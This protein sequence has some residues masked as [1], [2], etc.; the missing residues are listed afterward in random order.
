MSTKKTS[1]KKTA[2][3]TPQKKHPK[4]K[5]PSSQEY[6]AVAKGHLDRVQSAWYEPTDWANLTM[7]GLYCLEAGI[8]A[9][10]TSLSWDVK[11]THWDKAELAERLHKEQGLSDVSALLPVLN[12]GRKAMAYGDIDFDESEYDAQDIATE[13]E[14]F[15][16]DVEALLSGGDEDESD[17]ES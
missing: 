11:K 4:K 10:A 2:K 14:R 5:E 9:A 12:A 1:N 6:L 16:D 15:I 3:K 7:Y 8:L 13:I 17:D